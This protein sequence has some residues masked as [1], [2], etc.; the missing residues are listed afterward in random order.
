M[1]PIAGL[2]RGECRILLQPP[3]S[4]G[5]DL[6]FDN[7][8]RRYLKTFYLSGNLLANTFSGAGISIVYFGRSRLELVYCRKL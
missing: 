1:R 6:G 4:L 5:G 7:S 3:F 8:Q 2:R